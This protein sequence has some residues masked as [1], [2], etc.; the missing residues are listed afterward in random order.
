MP[1]PV[2]YRPDTGWVGDVIPVERDGELL[3]YFLHDERDR[4]EGTGWR[5]VRTRDLVTFQDDGV[6]LPAGDPGDDDFNA[7]TGSVVRAD[8]GT[9][10]LF[11]TGQNPRRLGSD[12]LPVQVV[13]HA[14]STDGLR[15]WVKDPQLRIG[16]TPG[17]ETADWRDPFVFRP[18]S[19]GPWRMLVTARHQ[20]GPERRRGVVAQ[21]LSD[22]LQQWRPAAP[23]WDPR[24]YIAHECPDVF[25]WGEWWYLVY[26]EFSERFATR[27]R[28]ARSPEGP[29]SVPD[30]DTVD[31]RAFYAGKTV[32]REGRRFFVGWIATRDGNRDD[33][34]WQWAGEM[35]IVEAHQRADGTL[36]FGLPREVVDSFT[37]VADLSFPD[38]QDG[39]DDAVNPRPEAKVHLSAPDGYAVALTADDPGLQF[40]ARFSVDIDP[41]TTELGVL[42]RS[43]PDGDASYCVRLE[44]QRQRLVFDRWPREVTGPMQWQVSGDVA[45]AVELERPCRIEPGTHQLDVLVDGDICVAVLDGSVVLSSRLYDRP[46]GRLGVFVGE[47]TATFFNTSLATRA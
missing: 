45:H 11:Y 4:A 31:G 14:V 15:T 30:L 35:S 5:L 6:A 47:G 39:P 3:L 33:G 12:G 40:L 36:D 9:A 2:F 23:F 42:L 24:R 22:D 21:L 27:Y 17:Y 43:S 1:K 46:S 37:D 18:N 41:D 16:S 28:I 32:E 29:W 44:P 8:D 13:M 25:K 38:G 10:H 19:A 7:Y 26:S 20:T 34:R